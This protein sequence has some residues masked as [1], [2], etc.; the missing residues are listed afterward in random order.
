M[1]DVARRAR[2]S[3]STVSLALRNSPLVAE[4][5]RAQILGLAAA[6]GYRVNPFVAAHMR[7]RRKPH[8]GVAAPVLAIVDTQRHRHGWRENRTTTVRRMLAGA[9]VQAAAR[10]YETR[11]FWLHEPGLSQERFSAMLRAR[12]I[13]G[14]LLGPSSDLHLEL[15][16]AWEWFSVVRL[17]SARVEPPLHRVVIDHFDL[18]MRAAQQAHELGFRRPLFPMREPFSKAHDRRMQSGFQSAWSHLP[19]VGPVG[20][21][22]TEGLADGPSLERWMRR[23]RPDVIVDNEERHLLDRL[24]AGGWRVPEEI[25]VLSMCAGISGGPLSGFVQDGDSMGIAG[26][27]L[28][29]AMIE[30]NE[31]GVPAVPV[32]LSTTAIWNRGETLR[33]EKAAAGERSRTGR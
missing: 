6:V 11:E 5:T 33:P 27:N 22:T 12:G 30:R 25:G 13:T 26:V 19:K 1:R 32:T 14:I 23:Y 2:V 16:L 18:G 31:T 21:P 10:G 9:R 29:I 17:G 28:L 20:M 7:T 24:R 4:A 15:K 8:A 3:T